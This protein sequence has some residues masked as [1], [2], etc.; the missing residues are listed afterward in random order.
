MPTIKKRK[1]K[2]KKIKKKKLK[3]RIYRKKIKL[4]RSNFLNLL[5]DKKKFQL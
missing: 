5:K 3:K 2:A 4:Y 1:K